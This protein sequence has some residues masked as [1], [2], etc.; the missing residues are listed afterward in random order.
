MRLV[1]HYDLAVL[2]TGSGNSIVDHRFDDRR[3]AVLEA[4]LFGGTCLNVGCIPTK[5]FVHPAELAR[6][7]RHAPDLGVDTRFEGARWREIRDRV[8]GRI[9]P[10]ESGGR[11]YRERQDN[12]DVYTG[13]ARFTGPRTIDTGTGQQIS[14]D[15]VV[16]ATGSR[17]RLPDLPGLDQVDFHTSDTVIR[18]EQLPARMVIIGGGYVAAEFAHVFSALGVEVVQV[19]R[20]PRL[21]MAQDEDVSQRFTELAQRQWDARLNLQPRGVRRTGSS[22][23]VDLDD[24]TSVEG[25]VLLL[26][27]GR[28][29]NTDDLGLDAAGVKTDSGGVIIVDEQQHTSADGVWALG[30]AANHFQLKHVANLEARTVQHNLLHPDD[31]RTSDHRFVPSAVFTSPQIASVGMTSQE[32]RTAGT[33]VRTVT[34]AYADVAYGWALEDTDHFVK[35][36]ATADGSRLL[37][38]HIIGPH[39]SLLIQ[40]LLQAMSLGSSP[41]EVARGQYWIHPALSEVVENALLQLG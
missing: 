14:A 20:G 33:D 9:D 36:L 41:Q 39:A 7:A 30:D 40:P 23:T 19:Q 32:A 21:L 6:A 22:I 24:D 16:V 29:P 1:T 10:I 2:G 35:L 17:V 37:G 34:Q 5:M 11:S 15:Q 8:F 26:A 25:D 4:E 13:H 12:V 27:T 38:A 18:L 28:V 31:P 3:V